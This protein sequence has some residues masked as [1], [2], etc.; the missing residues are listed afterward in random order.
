MRWTSDIMES[1]AERERTVVA[2]YLIMREDHPRNAGIGPELFF[3]PSHRSWWEES[4]RRDDFTSLDLGI[5]PEKSTA[6]A[7]PGYIVFGNQIPGMLDGMR[8]R[9]S[10]QRLLWA[11]STAFEDLRKRSED[12]DAICTELVAAV[13]DARAGC[14]NATESLTT[15][16]L[17]VL[18]TY[19]RDIKDK[20]S[21]TL[22]M[23][24]PAMQEALG[25]W[26]LGKLHL[27]VARSSEHKTT[28]TRQAAEHAA[29]TGHPVLYWTMEDS[30]EDIAIRDIA[31]RSELT[32]RDLAT[33]QVPQHLQLNKRLPEVGARARDHVMREAAGLFWLIDR[34]GP[35]LSDIGPTIGQAIA[36]HG[37]RAAALD[38]AQLIEAD[39]GHQDTGHWKRVAAYLAALAKR[40]RIA[41]LACC[42][43]DKF[44]TRESKDNED[45]GIRA[46]DMYGGISWMQSAFSV[47]CLWR[48]SDKRTITINVEKFKSAGPMRLDNVPVTPAHDRIEV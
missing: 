41:L 18:E 19:G 7:G 24:L 26:T 42:Q 39:S 25:G 30:S 47:T 2:Y 48:S 6:Y 5:T 13:E 29:H 34:G 9:W 14:S 43:I 44:A 22:P 11:T 35:K 37:I 8:R 33:A 3:D 46:E 4:L 10:I 21:R 45:R 36:K 16:G 12:M 17:R 28:F 38:F 1:D 15:V 40:H 31:S 32:T 23:F 20:S 27:I